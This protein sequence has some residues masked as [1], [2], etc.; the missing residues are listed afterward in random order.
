MCRA[1]STFQSNVRGSLTEFDDGR[2]SDSTSSKRAQNWSRAKPRFSD[3][4]ESTLGLISLHRIVQIGPFG[5]TGESDAGIGLFAL[6]KR[7]PDG[8]TR[9][10]PAQIRIRIQR[11]RGAAEEGP[12]NCCCAGRWCA[13]APDARLASVRS[14]SNAPRESHSTV[15]LQEEH[16]EFQ[17]LRIDLVQPRATE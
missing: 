13:C 16:I 7:A 1:R 15:C 5:M 3:K 17:L 4:P 6:R 10:A 8:A 9:G 14:Y 2:R 12:A 11:R